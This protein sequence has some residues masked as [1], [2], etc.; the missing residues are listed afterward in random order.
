MTQHAHRRNGMAR[1]VVVAGRPRVG[2]LARR[3]RA[4]ILDRFD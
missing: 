3:R 2:G 4:A 1:V